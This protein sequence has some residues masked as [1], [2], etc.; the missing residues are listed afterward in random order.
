MKNISMN[1]LN[2]YKSSNSLLIDVRLPNAYLKDHI[3]GA[4]NMPISNI[5]TML[6]NY[7]KNTP[8]ILYCDHGNLSNRAGRLLSS[9]GYT[10]IYI[11]LK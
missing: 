2:K 7:P 8:L 1:D 5:L 11:L 4:I 3:D 10:N 9:I 6:R